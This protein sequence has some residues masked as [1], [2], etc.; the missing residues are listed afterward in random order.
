MKR[1]KSFSRVEMLFSLD[2]IPHSSLFV[3]KVYRCF[4]LACRLHKSSRKRKL[5]F[6]EYMNALAQRILNDA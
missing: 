5:E 6:N 4:E 1:S 3:G 2:F